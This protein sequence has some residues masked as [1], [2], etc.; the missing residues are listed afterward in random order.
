MSM[1]RH[2]VTLDISGCCTRNG[3]ETSVGSFCA[4]LGCNN[5]EKTLTGFYSRV[6]NNQIELAALVESIKALKKPCEVTVRTSSKYIIETAT[7]MKDFIARGWKTKSGTEMA[8]KN[9]WQKLIQVAKEG[10]HHLTFQY[11]PNENKSRCEKI[12]KANPGFVALAKH[13]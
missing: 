12:A 7:S 8:N 6:T 10:N 3:M 1:N 2:I 9:A 13:D 4:I 11:I 5:Q